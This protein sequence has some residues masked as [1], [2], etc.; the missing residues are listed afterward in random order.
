MWAILIKMKSFSFMTTNHNCKKLDKNIVMSTGGKL[1]PPCKMKND[2]SILIVKQWPK[3]LTCHTIVK[4][5]PI[6]SHT[7]LTT[8]HLCQCRGGGGSSSVGPQTIRHWTQKPWNT[9]RILW[10]CAD[11]LIHRSH[12]HSG[13]LLSTC[14]MF[15]HIGFMALFVESLHSQASLASW[16]IAATS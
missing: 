13:W 7:T 15:L 16:W 14:F 1:L 11:S 3:G 5:F 12:W 4:H 9:T 6:M 8:R 2:L 10:R